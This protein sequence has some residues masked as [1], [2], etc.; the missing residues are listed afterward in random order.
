MRLIN[1]ILALLIINASTIGAQEAVDIQLESF[2]EVWG[3]INLEHFDPSFNGVNWAAQYERYKQK[4][5]LVADNEMFLE[6]ANEM[7][8]ELGQSHALVASDEMLR[9]YMP[10]LFSTGTVGVDLRWLNEKAVITK[11][12]PHSPAAR[13]PLRV[14]DEIVSIDGISI[15]SIVDKK[16]D[17]PPNNSRNE[18]GMI[19]HYLMGHL[20]GVPGSSVLI[21]YQRQNSVSDKTVLI[22]MKRGEGKLVSRAMP[23]LFVEFEA[24]R[25][26]GTIAYIWFNHF[27][28]PVDKQF[29]DAIDRLSE[30]SGLIIDL[31]GNPGGYF[32][33]MDGIVKKLID[34]E[35]NLYVFHFRDKTIERVLQPSKRP[36]PKPVA[37]II[38]ETSMSTSELFARS[39]QYIGRAAIVGNRSPG[40]LLGAQ[41][42][43]LPNKLSF[44]YPFIQPITSDGYIVENNGVI[45]DVAVDHQLKNLVEGRDSQL[46]AAI[47]FIRTAQTV[48]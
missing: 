2:E 8:F 48:F 27:A 13:A 43:R 19:A 6:L 24:Q 42:K 7:L 30:T 18:R 4:L 15:R 33:I 46:D 5:G 12:Q 47:K 39:L 36:Y 20:D 45:P 34:T 10:T 28:A 35:E 44:M 26:E 25:I 3:T 37:V 22:R 16:P 40:Y 17:L 41:W 23:P 21:E 32:K 11:V 29:S 9:R 1:S 31:R 38:D 14:G